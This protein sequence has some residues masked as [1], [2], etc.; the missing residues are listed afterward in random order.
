LQDYPEQPIEV[1]EGIT[2]VRIDRATGL[3]TN[4]FDHTSRFEY[5]ET[6]TQPL[7]YVEQPLLNNDGKRSNVDSVFDE[8]IF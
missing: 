5:F 6:G 7:K 8:D 3:L 4:R 1:P 2:T